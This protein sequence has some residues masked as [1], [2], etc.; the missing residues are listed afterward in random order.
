MWF[1][2]IDVKKSYFPYLANSMAGAKVLDIRYDPEKEDSTLLPVTLCRILKETSSVEDVWL[3][4]SFG[5][6]LER[7]N[8]TVLRFLGNQESEVQFALTKTI[9]QEERNAM[10]FSELSFICSIELIEDI[11]MSGELDFA[12]D[13]ALSGW[14]VKKAVASKL[15]TKWKFVNRFQLPG[16]EGTLAFCSSEDWDCVQFF[17]NDFSQLERLASRKIRF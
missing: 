10:P 1:D 4:S 3:F 14:L 5:P 9:K 7:R 17:S 8:L 2:L 16:P 6:L 15:L 12:S 13:L 11:F